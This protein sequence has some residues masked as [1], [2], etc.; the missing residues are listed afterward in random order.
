M[1]KVQGLTLERT[2]IRHRKR[3]ATVGAEEF[4]RASIPISPISPEVSREGRNLFLSDLQEVR[5]NSASASKVEQETSNVGSDPDTAPE[6]NTKSAEALDKECENTL[7]GDPELDPEVGATQPLQSEVHDEEMEKFMAMPATSFMDTLEVLGIVD[8]GGS[9]DP[10]EQLRR[11]SI[12]LFR[13]L[14][15]YRRVGRATTL[16]PNFYNRVAVR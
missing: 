16:D 12:N 1:P 2:G 7:A 4:L 9:P 5:A 15:V 11:E 10:D 3:F 14:G 6:A 13:S 8:K